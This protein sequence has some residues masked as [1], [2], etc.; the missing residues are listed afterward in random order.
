MCSQSSMHSVYI[1][2]NASFI[3]TREY[4]ILFIR[5]VAIYGIEI[6]VFKSHWF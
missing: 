2:G 6:A 5:I 3:G 1:I 4:N